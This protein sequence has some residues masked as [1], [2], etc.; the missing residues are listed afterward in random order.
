[1]NPVKIQVEP[2][3]TEERNSY[4]KG[5]GAGA[6]IL[7]LSAKAKI[8]TF[9]AGSYTEKETALDV[10]QEEGSMNLSVVNVVGKKLPITGSQMMLLLVA[11]GVTLMFV[12]VRKGKKRYE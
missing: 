3:V 1:M 10:D 11:A 9:I 7:T 8:K 5:E 2:V 6:D 12:S 4:I